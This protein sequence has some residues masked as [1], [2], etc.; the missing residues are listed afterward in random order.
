MKEIKLVNVESILSKQFSPLHTK[1]VVSVSDIENEPYV[2]FRIICCPQCGS[3]VYS[4][5][6]YH[7]CPY[8]KE[9]IGGLEF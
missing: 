4:T 2:T 6:D 5:P 3:F 7:Y 1:P 8:C 9:N